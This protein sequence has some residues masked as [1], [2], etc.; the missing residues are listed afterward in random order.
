MTE[1]APAA[2][3]F[4]CN[5]CG[6][7]PF[8]NFHQSARSRFVHRC[9][10]CT[11]KKNKEYFQA[12]KDTTL[13]EWRMRRRVSGGL[14]ITKLKLAEVFE[15]FGRRCFITGLVGPLT[16]I[17][18]DPAGE[19]TSSN[20]VPVLSM[21]AKLP[22]LPEASLTQWRRVRHLVPSIR[23]GGKASSRPSHQYE[24]TRVHATPVGTASEAAVAL[25]N[26]EASPVNA[27]QARGDEA[28]A[29]EGAGVIS[30]PPTKWATLVTK[31]GV[32]IA[33]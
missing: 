3:L 17:K 8:E 26:D 12:A 2:P 13:K 1:E 28:E 30:G 18:A 29:P 27:F 20:A 5:T 25:P 23:E 4:T 14:K 19:F 6:P 32:R 31:G 11:K 24:Q 7:L 16:L 22:H 33:V 9:K 21:L 15:I 10:E